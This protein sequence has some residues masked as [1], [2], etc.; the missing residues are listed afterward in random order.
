MNRL[1]ITG[2]MVATDVVALRLRKEHDETFTPVNEAIVRRQHEH[3]E[4]LGLGTSD[5][6]RLEIIELKV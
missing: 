5:L 6:S 3:A 1:I 4:E 2:D